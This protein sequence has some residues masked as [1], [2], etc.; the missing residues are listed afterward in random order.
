MRESV[1]II[2]QALDGLPEGPY[3]A[4]DRKVVLPPRDELLDLDGGA[5]PPLQARHRGLP[6]PAGRGLLPDRVAARR[7][8]LLRRRRRLGEARARALPRSLVRQ[9]AGAARHVRRRLRRRPDPE[10]RDAR[11]DPRRASTGERAR[12]ELRPDGREDRRGP[13]A[14]DRLDAPRTPTSPSSTRS[15]SRDELRE[16]IEEAMS[17]YPQV[18]SASIPALWA[19][20]RHYGWCSPEGIR[21]AAAVMGVTPAYLESVASFYDLFAPAGRPPPC[22]RLPQHLLLDARRR[23]AARGVLRCGRRRSPRGRPRRRQLRRRRVSCRASSAWAPATSRRWP[24]S[25]SAT[26]GRSTRPTPRPRRAAALRRRG[27]ARQGA[28]EAR[29][30]GPD[31]EPGRAEPP[32]RG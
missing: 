13:A 29:R 5:D 21:Q 6:G 31:P 9:P 25:T 16:R 23:R 2:E 7:A 24:R 27:P 22:S 4:D 10:P 28:G 3:I 15:T 20:Q 1:K 8:R 12:R 18:R 32:T 11:P 17:R 26:T 19:V 14:A 30:G